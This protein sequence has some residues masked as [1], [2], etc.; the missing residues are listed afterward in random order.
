[1]PVTAA[2]RRYLSS[3]AA[4]PRGAF[5]RLL[6]RIWRTETAG[7]NRVAL[8]LLAPAPG[9]RI[10]EIGFGPGRT[11]GLLAG[12]GAEV[13]GVEVSATMLAVAARYNAKSIAAGLISLRRG[14]GIRLPIADHSLDKV[15]SVHNFYFWPDPRTSLHDI[16]RALRPGGRLVLT[17]LSD[18][19]PLAARFDPAIY[20]LPTTGETT[21]WL[22]AAGFIDVC[23][24][25]RS[26]CEST[27]WFTATAT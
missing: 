12:A 13:I 7:V 24:T 27:V 8:E 25:R 1:M 2:A 19:R 4:R 6:G 16:A 11:L 18:D 21:A 23:I 9:E 20:R 14:D 26:A 15:L 22:R 17:S 10:C 5:G 3:Q